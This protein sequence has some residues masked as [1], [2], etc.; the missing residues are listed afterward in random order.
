MP[1]TYVPSLR[2]K[3]KDVKVEQKDVYTPS[4]RKKKNS[5]KPREESKPENNIIINIPEFK[6]TEVNVNIPDIKVPN[7]YIPEIKIPEPKAA[8]I[9]IPEIKIP[10]PKAAIINIPEIKIPEPKA[11]I[12][13]IPEIKIPEPKAAIINI[14][15]IKMPDVNVNIPEIKIP[16]IVVNYDDKHIAIL[17]DILKQMI[18]SNKI[19]LE[20]VSAAA[21]SSNQSADEATSHLK[22]VLELTKDLHRPIATDSADGDH[23]LD[24]G[25]ALRFISNIETKAS[26]LGELQIVRDSLIDSGELLKFKTSTQDVIVALIAS[27]GQLFRDVNTLHHEII[28]NQ[29]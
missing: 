1:E 24:G 2:K 20:E 13:N 8:I 26:I 12:I 5:E 10:E 16:Q 21:K 14:P 17:S 7:V 18:E 23:P 6:P 15:E 3:A 22:K 25:S 28:K 29:S 19:S 11:A 9:N 27:V 4:L